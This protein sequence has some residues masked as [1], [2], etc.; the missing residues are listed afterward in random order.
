MVGAEVL[1]TVGIDRISL[2]ESG[3]GEVN[4]EEITF[5]TIITSIGSTFVGNEA[6]V[7]VDIVEVDAHGESNLECF[8]TSVLS[9]SDG[10]HANDVHTILTF[11]DRINSHT[12]AINVEV[13]QVTTSGSINFIIHHHQ[14]TAVFSTGTVKMSSTSHLNAADD[15]AVK[16]IQSGSSGSNTSAIFT[17]ISLTSYGCENTLSKETSISNS[18]SEERASILQHNISFEIVDVLNL[19][20]HGPN[21]NIREK[22]VLRIRKNGVEIVVLNSMVQEANR[23]GESG[24]IG[25]TLSIVRENLNRV[26]ELV[27]AIGR[28]IR[29]DQSIGAELGGSIGAPVFIGA[30]SGNSLRAYKAICAIDENR[31]ASGEIDALGNTV[32]RLFVSVLGIV[33]TNTKGNLI[34]I[35]GVTVVCFFLTSCK[36]N[37]STSSQNH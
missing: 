19:V 11:D 25:I 28:N 22:T 20:V 26:N 16:N 34:A 32:V 17:P 12:L 1:D 13:Q 7:V 18:G 29:G 36:E 2:L 33:D 21:G 23:S 8:S 6:N 3:R 37:Q 30:K 9:R 14:R 27:R 15:K 5:V 31:I 10:E 24:G 4:M 35:D